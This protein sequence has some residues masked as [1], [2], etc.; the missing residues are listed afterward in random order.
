MR[1]CLSTVAAVGLSVGLGVTG[2]AGQVPQ[3]GATPFGSV[4]DLTPMSSV[5]AGEPMRDVA[6]REVPVYRSGLPAV[7]PSGEPGTV[8]AEVPL[9]ARVG[10]SSASK[11]FR[12]AYTTVDQ[13]GKPATS[14]GAVFLPKG[15]KPEGGWPVLAWAHGTVGLGD[16]C[17]P[18]INARSARDAEYLNRWLTRGTRSWP[19]IMLGWIRPGC[20]AT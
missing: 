13:H 14:T 19:R 7:A 18:S 5:K 20:T 10:L 8:L 3:A 15:E 17:A 2:L 16:E 11:Q 9:D 12:V 4:A 1:K 6:P